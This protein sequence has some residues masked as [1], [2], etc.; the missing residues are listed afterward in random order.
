MGKGI[1]SVPECGE[2]HYARTYCRSHYGRWRRSG[3][4]LKPLQQAPK[5]R[6]SESWIEDDLPASTYVLY[7]LFD[8][9]LY[10]GLTGRGARRLREHSREKEWW[11]QARRAEFEHF[12]SVREARKKEWEL[13]RRLRPKYNK[14]PLPQ[15]YFSI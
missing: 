4:P 12:S 14:K 8:K 11:E 13:V 2:E 10:V 7:G 9:V 1:C 15:N 3:N 6:P 5:P